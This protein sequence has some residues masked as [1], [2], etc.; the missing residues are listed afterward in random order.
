MLLLQILLG[1]VLKARWQVRHRT[2]PPGQRSGGG[3][4]DRIISS[5]AGY[6]PMRLT[7]QGSAPADAPSGL[8]GAR[9]ESPISGRRRW[10]SPGSSVLRWQ[11]PSQPAPR[12]HLGVIACEHGLLPVVGTDDG[13]EIRI[14][15]SEGTA[16]PHVQCKGQWCRTAGHRARLLSGSVAMREQCSAWRAAFCG[17]PGRGGGYA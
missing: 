2:D 4:H 11:R 13:L 12:A 5:D 3:R 7:W 9:H 17:E 1:H 16:A 15:P 14:S 10:R 6:H 8:A